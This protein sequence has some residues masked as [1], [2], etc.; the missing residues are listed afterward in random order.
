[1][2]CFVWTRSFQGQP[3]F[4]GRPGI[5]GLEVIRHDQISVSHLFRLE[6]YRVKKIGGKK[7]RCAP[8]YNC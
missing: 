5:E 4:N 3:G 7:I 8:D 6:L 1:M 2:F